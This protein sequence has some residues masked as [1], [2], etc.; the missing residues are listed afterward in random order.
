METDP[1]IANTARDYNMSGRIE[2]F[3]KNRT[4]LS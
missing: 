4:E 3:I 2:K 1:F